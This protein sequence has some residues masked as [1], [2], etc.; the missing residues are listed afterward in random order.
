MGA[1][2]RATGGTEA[3]RRSHTGDPRSKERQKKPGMSS[4]AVA[5][6]SPLMSARSTCAAC[7]IGP[8]CNRMSLSFSQ[9][10]GRSE[11]WR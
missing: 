2:W 6:Q 1:A 10:D 4:A 9:E 11:E 5:V 3:R 8:Y 7:I